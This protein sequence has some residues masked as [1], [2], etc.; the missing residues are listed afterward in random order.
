MTFRLDLV[1]C[2]RGHSGAIVNGVIHDTFNPSR[3]ENG[4]TPFVYGQ[5]QAPERGIS[6]DLKQVLDAVTKILALADST[7]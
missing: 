1:V 5:T 4:K 6:V 3:K 7:N 2:I